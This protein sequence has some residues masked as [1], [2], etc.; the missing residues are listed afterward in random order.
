MREHLLWK[1]QACTPIKQSKAVAVAG[2]Y[3]TEYCIRHHAATGQFRTRIASHCFDLGCDRR[4]NIQ[5]AR[6][7]VERGR[8]RV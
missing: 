8:R 1:P 3:P 4:Y 6:S 2:F 7:W 5:M